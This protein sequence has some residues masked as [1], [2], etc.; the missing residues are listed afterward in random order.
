MNSL[1]RPHPESVST[2]RPAVDAGST[3]GGTAPGQSAVWGLSIEELHRAFW[4]TCRIAVV[5][6]G[7]AEPLAGSA[8][9]Y[10]LLPD[11][12]WVWFD[13]AQVGDTLRWLKPQVLNLRVS[14][15][16]HESYAERVVLNE[17]GRFAS[18]ERTYRDVTQS[19][20]RTTLVRSRALAE[21]WRGAADSEAAAAAL[22]AVGRTE[23]ASLDVSGQFYGFRPRPGY[24][25]KGRRGRRVP[26]AAGDAV[27]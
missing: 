16:S 6:Y 25:G 5:R 26:S 15:R 2:P 11:D 23:Q 22:R 3:A 13:P 9:L 20:Y 18:I 24:G 10:L 8:D 1:A 19:A 27:A 4:S 14:V 21:T 12:A 17:A 7:S